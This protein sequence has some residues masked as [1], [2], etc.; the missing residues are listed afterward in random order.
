MAAID[1]PT[2]IRLELYSS[3]QQLSSSYVQML[4]TLTE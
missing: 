1:Y 4:K 2:G 3:F